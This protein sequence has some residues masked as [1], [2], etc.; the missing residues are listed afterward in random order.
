M[1][2][3]LDEFET[4]HCAG[5]DRLVGIDD[6]GVGERRYRLKLVGDL[7][8]AELDRLQLGIVCIAGEIV[9]LVTQHIGAAGELIL[10]HQRAVALEFEDF[11]KNLGEGFEFPGQAR[12]LIEA[13]RT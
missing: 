11:G 6:E 1:Q 12:D 9:E 4:R 8:G 2:R 5:R 13:R 3:V 10:R 7:L